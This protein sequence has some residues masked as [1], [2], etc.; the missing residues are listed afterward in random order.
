MA[1]KRK[2]E[3][4]NDSPSSIQQITA[5]RKSRRQI[6]RKQLEERK[7]NSPN[8]S[9]TNSGEDQNKKPGKKYNRNKQTDQLINIYDKKDLG[10]TDVRLTLDDVRQM[11]VGSPLDKTSTNEI[12]IWSEEVIEETIICEEMEVD[13]R[14]K[15][16]SVLTSSSSSSPTQ[17]CYK[18]NDQLA[19]MQISDRSKEI[20]KLVNDLSSLDNI[21]SPTRCAAATTP[22]LSPPPQDEESSSSILDKMEQIHQQGEPDKLFILSNHIQIEE[23]KLSSSSE[24]SN[25]TSVSSNSTNKTNQDPTGSGVRRSSRIRSIGLMKQRSRGRGLVTKSSTVNQDFIKNQSPS[26][27]VKNSPDIRVDIPLDKDSGIKQGSLTPSVDSQSSSAPTSTSTGYDS[28]SSKPVKVK[29]RWRRSSELEMSGSNSW[30]NVVNNSSLT[31]IL[32]NKI[33]LDSQSS[34]TD[35]KNGDN[36]NILTINEIKDEG[37]E[38]RLNQFDY[39]TE[40]LYLTDRFT[41]KETKGMV[42]DCFLTE[43]EIERGELGCG[44]DCLNR[45]LMIECGPRCV[46]GNRCTNKR[47]QNN[48]YAKCEVFK[49]EKKGLG[50]RATADIQV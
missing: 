32:E 50:L 23:I 12:E 41:N 45:L 17:N 36:G 15:T 44:E 26:Q 13:D 19:D 46:V 42:C 28:D 6:A 34:Q 11:V 33:T 9:A 31:S 3:V 4:K 30:T 39:L 16:E 20:E 10:E 40:N 1:R 48:E 5:V 2:N 38:E 8:E 43:E 47:F 14:S 24:N 29:S 25:D 7:I 21:D 49:T 27:D 37:M 18:L 22:K 35:T